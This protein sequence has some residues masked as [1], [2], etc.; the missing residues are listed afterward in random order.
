MG[1]IENE[2]LKNNGFRK[3]KTKMTVLHWYCSRVFV[4][5]RQRG[6]GFRGIRRRHGGRTNERALFVSRPQVIKRLILAATA[7]VQRRDSRRTHKFVPRVPPMTAATDPGNKLTRALGEPCPRHTSRP[8]DAS[9]REIVRAII[10][11]VAQRF[12]ASSPTT[13]LRELVPH[14]FEKKRKNGIGRRKS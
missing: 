12:H 14:F 6:C 4:A 13:I 3:K 8:L 10:F 11:A 9:G 7:A 1:E 2:K 5:E